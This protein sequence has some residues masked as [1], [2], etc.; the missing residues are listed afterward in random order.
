MMATESSFRRDRCLSF[1]G[2]THF[3]DTRDLAANAKKTRRT[4][5]GIKR[6]AASQK[7]PL[8]NTKT[9]PKQYPQSVECL[10]YKPKLVLAKIANTA[11]KTVTKTAAKTSTVAST[12]TDK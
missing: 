3:A 9:I 10:V 2:T 6:R 4:I 7:D 12:S 8:C 1:S 5:Q 11:S